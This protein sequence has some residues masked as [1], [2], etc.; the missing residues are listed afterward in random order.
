MNYED[1][2]LKEKYFQAS[3]TLVRSSCPGLGTSSF[4]CDIGYLAQ[5]GVRGIISLNEAELAWEILK[6][7]DIH[8]LQSPVRDHQPPEFEQMQEIVRFWSE[9]SP[10]GLICV[11]CNAGQGIN[12]FF[13]FFFF[14]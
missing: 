1:S 2:S 12:L 10:E 8:H 7:Y 11:H 3:S 13:F 9:Y 5:Q 6:Q 4:E 14:S